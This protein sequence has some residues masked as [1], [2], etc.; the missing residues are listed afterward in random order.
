MLSFGVL[1]TKWLISKG[2]LARPNN[3]AQL[4]A[5]CTRGKSNMAGFEGHA[6]Q[7]KSGNVIRERV[8]TLYLLFLCI[9]LR[10]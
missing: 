4:R 3:F 8:S 2:I 10:K 9:D 1:G 6:G 5:R 7:K